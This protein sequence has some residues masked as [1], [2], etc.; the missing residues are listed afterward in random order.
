MG[1]EARV[2]LYARSEAAAIEAAES[3]F[4]SIARLEDVLSDWRA[5]SE[6]AQ[7]TSGDAHRRVPADTPHVDA[8]PVGPIVPAPIPSA[9]IPVS[10]ILFDALSRALDVARRS[11]GA[12]DP[13]IGPVVSLWREARR[14]GRL[15]DPTAL[16]AARSRVG[17][18]FV[19]LDVAAR[20]VVLDRPDVR[21][22]L[23]G[24]GKGYACQRAIEALRERDVRSALVQMGGD[25][26]CSAAP[27]GR[28][29]W[30]VD[31][32]PTSSE[33]TGE[34]LVLSDVALSTSGDREQHVVIDGVTYSHVVDPSTGIGLTTHARA[35]VLAP[36][37][38]TSDGLSTALT[39]VGAAGAP[40]LLARFPQCEAWIEDAGTL[41]LD[42]AAPATS[43]RFATRGWAAIPRIDRLSP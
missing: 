34:R 39:V 7:L 4:A 15:P 6:L 28:A 42:S 8:A 43:R 18:R 20:A 2:V 41:G 16:A 33:S 11:E 29:G 36:D 3:A 23:G 26:V 31:L 22:D 24:I 5:D 14:S 30:D 13:T 37:G 27:P 21:F 9:P 10:A 1:G 35:I 17:Y 40:A 19:H 32:A 12:F 25:L 38:A